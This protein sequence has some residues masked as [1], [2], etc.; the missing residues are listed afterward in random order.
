[1][2]TKAHEKLMRAT[3]EEKKHF[4]LY[5]SGRNWTI[6]GLA[7]LF[8][9]V[10]LTQQP[11]TTQAATVETDD[12]NTVTDAN[13]ATTAKTMV[14][15]PA[16][17]ATI[18]N[19]TL[20]SGAKPTLPTVTMA[21]GEKAPAWTLADF[22]FS[23]VDT[24]KAGTYAVSLS[25]A[26][27]A[28]LQAA[29]PTQNVTQATVKSGQVVV[30]AAQA[31]TTADTTSEATAKTT[32]AADADTTPAQATDAKQTTD[33]TT[34]QAATDTTDTTK[35]TA[36][37]SDDKQQA[38]TAKSQ[39][40]T[41]ATKAS[42]TPAD[43]T[44]QTDQATADKAQSTTQVAD[45]KQAQTRTMV[46]ATSQASD[47]L[48]DPN[49]SAAANDAVSE[50]D[51][52]NKVKLTLSTN[53]VGYKTGTDMLIVTLGM[54]VNVG[55]KISIT[56]PT[57]K[58]VIGW[59]SAQDFPAGTGTGEMTTNADGTTTYNINITSNSQITQ[60]LRLKMRD[61]I[62]RGAVI[63]NADIGTTTKQV[64]WTVNGV[65]QTP[66]TLTQTINPTADPQAPARLHPD[67]AATPAVAANSPVVYQFDLGLS[68][69]LF[70][71]KTGGSVTQIINRNGATITIP[72]PTDFV[73]DE[74]AT[75]AY[76]GL[77]N[78]TTITQPGGQ[79]GDVVITV[80]AN[81]AVAYNGSG[82]PLPYWLVGEYDMADPSA[83]TPVE[84]AG[85]AV[86]QQTMDD[87]K[88][89][90]FTGTD[91]WHDVIAHTDTGN[92]VATA[93]LN[94][95][96]NSGS[97]P[98]KLTLD[99]N[100]DN[101]P[102][103]LSS[104]TFSVNA[105]APIAGSHFIITIPDGVDATGI[106]VPNAGN[107]RNTYMPSTTSYTYTLTMADG[108]T[109][110]GTVAPGE[111]IT[112]QGTSAIRTADLQPDVLDAG[113]FTTRD[114]DNTRDFSV[115]GHLA[116]KYD[117]GDDVKDGD[118]LKFDYRYEN[119]DGSF[120]EKPAQETVTAAIATALGY[121]HQ[122]NQNL[123]GTGYVSL[124]M[125]GNSNQ[126][127]DYIYEPILYFVIPANASIK[128][129]NH[130]ASDTVAPKIT[131]YTTA[132]GRTGVKYDYTGTGEY[133]NTLNTMGPESYKIDLINT[134]DTTI[135]DSYA[136]FYITSPTTPLNQTVKVT[137]PSDKTQATLPNLDPETLLSLTDGD[138]NAV[139]M[140]QSPSSWTVDLASAQTSVSLAQGNENQEPITEANA[141]A[142]DADHKLIFTY[143]IL[144]TTKTPTTDSAAVLNLPTAGDA[145]GSTFTYELTGPIHVPATSNGSGAAI[146][147]T[148]LYSTSAYT[149]QA[150]DESAPVLD[151]FVP[152]DQITDWSQ[153]RAVYVY[154]GSVVA[155]D[156]TGRITLTGTT[157]DF[158]AQ[159]GDVGYLDTLT[160][161]NSTPFNEAK[162]TKI[163]FDSVSKVTAKLHYTD[164]EGV[165][166][167]IDL[168]DLNKQNAALIDGK[169]K[170]NY[171]T[172]LSGLT[173]ADQALVPAD[174]VLKDVTVQ[175]S[176]ADYGDLPNDVAENGKVSQY[177]FDGDV[178]VYEL[179]KNVI[180]TTKKTITKTIHYETEN[181]TKIAEDY[182]PSIEITETYNP[183]T[184]TTTDT[185]TDAKLGFQEL[186][187]KAGYKAT[188]I[189]TEATS[190]TPVMF[191]SDDI[192]VTVI[193]TKD[194]P[195]ITHDTVNKTVHYVDQD[196]HTL[197]PDFTDQ[198][199]FTESTDAIDNTIKTDS[200]ESGKLGH[201]DNPPIDGYHVVANPV[202]ATTDQTVK[203]GDKDIEVTVVYD[204]NAPKQALD[205]VTKTV[206]Y[207][208]QDGHTL[209]PD[210]TDQANFTELTD[211]VTGDKID[212]P[213]SAKLA[214]QTNPPIGGYHVVT[215]PVEATT[216]QTVK[217]G[218]KDIEVTVVYDKNAP[219][220][221]LDTVTKTVHYVD[222]DGH[223]LAPDYTDQ[224]NFT[225]L[226]DPVTGD[227]IDGPDS[228]KLA[229]QTNP[230]IGGYHVVTNPV[231][232]TTDQTV[233]FGDKDIEVTV[234]YDKNAPKQA[235]DTVTKI[236]HYVDQDGHRLAKDF[237]EHVNFTQVTDPVTGDV[238]SGPE[239]AVLAK[240]ANP[241][242]AGYHVVDSPIEAT[243]DQ[244]VKFGDKDIEVTVVYDKN[245]PKQAL[246]TV[247]KTIHYVDQDGH[248]LAKD[249]TEH[250]NFT[251]VTDPVTGDVTSG[252]ESAVLAKK[253]NPTLAGYHVVDSPIEATTDQTVKFGDKDI[254]VTVVYDKNAPKQALDTVTKT[255]HYVDQDGHQ[256]TDDFTE[257]VNFTQVTDPVTGDVTS[258]P[259]SAVLAKKANPTFAGYHV[260]DSP[261]EATTDQTIK[262]GDKDIE[263]TVVYDKNA[264]KQA[265]DTVT[266]TIH[267]VD[268]DGNTLAPDFTDHANFTELTDALTGAKAY[269]PESATLSYQ[270]NPI[271]SG[272]HVITSP[273]GATADETVKYGDA[274]LNYTVVYQLN[275]P[276]QQLDTVTKTVHYVDIEG[277]PLAADFTDHANFTE[278]TDA[279]TGAKSY[280]PTS[281]TLGYQ[282]NPV[283]SGLS[284]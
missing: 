227:K 144:N 204:K 278:L 92:A 108:T 138:A 275:A 242:L 101:D 18:G 150:S 183:A 202:E 159:G 9:G 152:A 32:T 193:Y 276:A 10:M 225:E 126:T 54:N 235:L 111:T 82:V 207:V 240:K 57:D 67:G 112:R 161:M 30:E 65:K 79:G 255:I 5:K 38:A 130:P 14:P 174:Y 2:H 24:S 241:T 143:N 282:D 265:L 103:S 205:T 234:V 233:K 217:F 118:V 102:A 222:Q 56:L 206:H 81:A 175:N 164:D 186:P 43:A 274:D 198:A 122:D 220:Q 125:A 110:T 91:K 134:P 252:P 98:D 253:A 142:H 95:F 123:G 128:T 170:L 162:T 61:N 261:I 115:I 4:K 49:A 246:D 42:D 258:G 194:D 136:D 107:N 232:A 66:L 36:A 155:G 63:T 215:N 192:D 19:Q 238:T 121:K 113:A 248:Q 35:A 8:S 40:V 172:E 74:T 163:T 256:L 272:Y 231:E 13:A 179:V 270:D 75:A 283:I 99:T 120:T 178:I 167:N 266:K 280:G 11:Q 277:N 41:A 12:T 263:V 245:A 114:E 176:T 90:T 48:S 124:Q 17:V 243:T 27:L 189:P 250:V 171:P 1:M 158:V 203:F 139:Q 51:P 109:Q 228:A 34:P 157:K 55:D 94:T 93:T 219:K 140:G 156:A 260:V 71:D 259:E 141:E 251:Q 169:D 117:G 145:Q 44:A 39:P 97:A 50:T 52:T 168:P 104:M 224:A 166:H 191:A 201:Q 267:Y 262:F 72:A 58:T 53:K 45:Q 62:N 6:A 273:K 80:P 68:T 226:T 212:G 247:T 187:Q 200:P 29:N 88:V 210:Y 284:W 21:A 237:T 87:G 131:T 268:Q 271:I 281:A 137:E 173:T 22:D 269:G 211:P 221:A 73:L 180:T 132:D 77:N 119:S 86:Y 199:S 96:G 148:V 16:T 160:Y 147:A 105:V 197:A 89:L 165:E 154:F 60:E 15:T 59:D 37:T 129:I 239:S 135:S 83:D 47:D 151:Q 64:T 70:D 100:T 196:G 209:A 84:A 78:G 254:E 177:Y 116:A 188:T 223:T 208:D 249:F 181:G 20:Q 184:N 213:D 25:S 146:N 244:T 7:L 257:H 230:P 214:H 69:G 264:P 28:A 190:D 185:P 85:P 76:N 216:D 182:T 279:L 153:V 149:P 127:T 133:V 23:Q 195:I 26:G 3:Y 236:I 46:A 106:K 229:H 31:D 218:D 33:A